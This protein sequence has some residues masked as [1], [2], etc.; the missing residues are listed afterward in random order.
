MYIH[1]KDRPTMP[2]C[3]PT[4]PM[5]CDLFGGDYSRVLVFVLLEGA[6]CWTIGVGVCV[7]MMLD[8]IN[9]RIRH[10]SPSTFFSLRR[11]RRHLL[12]VADLFQGLAGRVISLQSKPSGMRG[13][14]PKLSNALTLVAAHV[15]ALLQPRPRARGPPCVILIDLGHIAMCLSIRCSDTAASERRVLPAETYP[16]PWAYTT[17]ARTDVVISVFRHAVLLVDRHH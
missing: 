14:S 2:V 9:I 16:L 12:L 11:A 13:R 6:R 3:R 1:T 10:L 8:G 7:F 17:F 15:A 5:T 4:G